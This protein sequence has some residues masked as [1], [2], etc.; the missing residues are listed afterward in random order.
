LERGEE[1]QPEE[2]PLQ[3]SLRSSVT[4]GSCTTRMGQGQSTI[5]GTVAPGYES[6]RDKF[7]E[8]F[9][10]GRE[11]SAQLCVYVGEEKVVDLWGSI[12]DKEFTGDSI[13][14]VFSST[15][16]LA[17]I[18]LASLVDR[19]LLKYSDKISKHWPEFGQNGKENVT[20]ADLM[21]HEAGL[22]SFDT[23]LTPEDF[24]RSG[25]KAN[26]VGEVVARQEQDFPADGNRRQY[27]AVTRGW[28]INELFRRVEPSGCTIGEFLESHVSR[29]FKAGVYIGGSPS[30]KYV[31]TEPLSVSYAISQSFIPQAIGRGVDPNFFQM[32]ELFNMFRKFKNMSK[33]AGKPPAIADMD[34]VGKI[35]NTQGV[36]E[37]EVPSANGNCSA[38][39]LARVAAIMANGGSLQGQA[40]L[41]PAGWDAFHGDPVE[42]KLFTASF[43][44][45]QGGVCQFED[46]VSPGRGGY[47][48]WMGFGG[49][50]FQWHPELKIGFGYVPTLLTWIDLTNNKARLLQEEVRKCAAALNKA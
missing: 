21:R 14:N 28:V 15:K 18:A 33:D 44:F 3:A 19:G 37:G 34:A 26:K 2:N 48:G 45:T 39:G 11:T 43:K 16:S 36:R 6:V 13:T 12:K 1:K 27:H 31:D 50:V 41:S 30:E 32:I 46:E 49:S 35:W 9:R 25:I 5:E 42:G 20:V 4:T 22:A 47:F 29:P 23:S 24:S 40:L 17:A 8:N 7:E 38:R 10:T